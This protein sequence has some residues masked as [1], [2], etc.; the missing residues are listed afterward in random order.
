VECDAPESANDP[1]YLDRLAGL[2]ADIFIVAD[3][4]EML[5]K[6]L[7]GTPRIG[8]FNLHASLLPAYR[9]AAPVVHAL[10]AGED[11][12]GVTLFRV[13]KGLDTGPIVGCARTEIAPLETAGELEARLARLGA[14]L[15]D[16]SLD[17]FDAGTFRE[18]LQ[19][20]RLATRA[21]KLDKK[22]GA[23]DWGMAP[24]AL[25]DFVRALNP[26]PGAFSFMA[27]RGGALERTVFL[28]VKPG[29]SPGESFPPGAVAGVRKD[30]FSV[31]AGDGAVEVLELQREGKA[32]LSAAAY[33]RGRQLRPGD[34]FTSGP[35]PDPR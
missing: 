27:A 32:P 20:E 5:R 24:G 28:R 1:A 19:D 18:T 31:R 15:L 17:A 2:G 9:G 35:G 34:V 21:P 26:W 11:V 30:G 3:Y 23:I 29:A 14:E 22:A 33:L 16:A 8:T 13:E 12:T 7:R 25:T 10:L 6:R 4:G